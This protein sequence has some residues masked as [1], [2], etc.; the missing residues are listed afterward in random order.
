MPMKRAAGVP[1]AVQAEAT[2]RKLV[3]IAREQFAAR[4]Y[5]NTGTEHLVQAA[6]LTRGA[7][8]HHFGSKEG[9]F[10]AVVDDVQREVGER[11][12]SAAAKAAGVRAGLWEQFVAGCRAFLAAS[13]DPH[14]QRIMLVDAPA[15]LGWDAWREM[16]SQYSLRSLEDVLA[17]MAEEGTLAL[18]STEAVAHLL[19]GAMNEAALWIARAPSPERALGEAT[20]ALELLLG[21][22]RAPRRRG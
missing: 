6:G 15:V 9:L 16:D 21:A 12:E 20:E 19:S 11:V 17:A 22:L 18:A 3:A 7:L 14:V 10:R 5:A 13:L 1:K 4:G 8:Y 2:T